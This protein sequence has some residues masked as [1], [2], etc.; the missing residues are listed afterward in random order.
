MC[1]C[2]ECGFE[3]DGVPFA[4]TVSLVA[5]FPRVAARM[6]RGAPELDLRRNPRPVMWSALQYAV[7]TGEALSWYRARIHRVLTEPEPRLLPFDWDAACRSG[8][9]HER[10][11]GQ[12]LVDLD[13]SA[14]AFVAELNGLEPSKRLR[15]GIGSD[16]SPRSIEELARRAAHEAAH[17]A[18]DIA[19]VLDEVGVSR[20]G[21][22]S[23]S[24]AL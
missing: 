10:A 6:L 2:E 22:S 23:A 18:R 20:A 12:V 9:Y 5:G 15:C 4:A 17:H 3:V 1:P 14:A 21:G 13:H 11:T 24:V 16:G 7:H 8:R 19:A